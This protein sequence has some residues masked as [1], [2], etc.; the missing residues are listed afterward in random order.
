MPMMDMCR[1]TMASHTMGGGD[2][3]TDGRGNDLRGYLSVA[4][5]SGSHWSAR[6]V[7]LTRSRVA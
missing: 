2:D 7:Q 1:A 5:W 6:G 3:M 4:V